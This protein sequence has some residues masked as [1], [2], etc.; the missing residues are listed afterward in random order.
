[1]FVIFNRSN[2]STAG[3][4]L[5]SVDW[6]NGP[7]RRFRTVSFNPSLPVIQAYSADPDQT[8]CSAASEMSLH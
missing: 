1:M 2:G 3:R 6:E 5:L 7:E 4:L 8:P